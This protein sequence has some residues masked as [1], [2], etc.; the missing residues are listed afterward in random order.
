MAAEGTVSTDDSNVTPRPPGVTPP[1]VIPPIVIVVA[2]AGMV[3]PPVVMTKNVEVV[4]PHVAVSVKTL[5]D[6]APTVG[7]TDAA[8]KSTG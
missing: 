2:A 4:A 3:A 5:L 1:S 6:P 7:V 8:K